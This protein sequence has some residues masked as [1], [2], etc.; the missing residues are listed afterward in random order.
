MGV[1]YAKGTGVKK[2][3]FK[4]VEFYKK[5]CDLDDGFECFNLGVHQL[6]MW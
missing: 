6:S 3:E 2:D 4:A 1:M 5:A